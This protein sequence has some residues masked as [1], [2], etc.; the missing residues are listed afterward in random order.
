MPPANNFMSPHYS[1]GAENLPLKVTVCKSCFLLQT[2]DFIAPQ[3]IFKPDYVYL[4]S[5]SKTWVDHSKDYVELVIDKLN[6]K[7][8]SSFIVEIASNDGYLLQFFRD[9]GFTCLGIEPTETAALIARDKGIE[10]YVEF[11]DIKLAEKI[12]KQKGQAKLIAANNVLA[13]VPQIKE[14][15]LAVKALLHKKGTV[16]FE[17]PYAINLLELNQYDTIYHEHFSY[18]SLSPLVKLFGSIGMEIYYLDYLETHGGSLRIYVGH[19]AVFSIDSK[20]KRAIEKERNYGLFNI[21][22]YTDWTSRVKQHKYSVVSFLLEKAIKQKTVYAYGAAAKGNTLLNYCGINSD[23]IKAIID[24]AETKIGKLA[25]GSSI[26][27]ISPNS[28][29]FS[30]IDCIVIL[31]WNI[32]QEI[33]ISL[34]S[35]YH[36]KGEIITLSPKIKIW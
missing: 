14:F 9:K 16:T 19:K 15:V 22:C 24:K 32:A 21:D 25:P 3:D 5:A 26:P 33:I 13:H 8:D 23:Y 30:S 29:D 28:T 7:K 10:T 11:F 31:P 17:F 36:F 27:V 6:L 12:K 18:L 4:S 1:G 35:E 20:V 2:V 34:R